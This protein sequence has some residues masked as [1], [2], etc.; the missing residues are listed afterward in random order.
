MNIEELIND[1]KRREM[2]D[3]EI[4]KALEEL[5]REGKITPEDFEHAKEL[6][7]DDDKAKAEKLFGLKFN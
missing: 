6:L 1:F 4:M 5:T 7:H 3:E 2:S